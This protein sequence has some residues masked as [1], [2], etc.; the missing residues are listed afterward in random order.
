MSG[1]ILIVDDEKD[2]LVLLRRIISEKTDHQLVTECDPVMA[3][4]LFKKQS[5]DLVIVDLKMPRMD[6]IK[7]L[8]EV[9]MSQRIS[10]YLR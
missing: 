1:R 2:M 10:I 4:E 5:F 3:L 9:F 8:E 6:G 7:L